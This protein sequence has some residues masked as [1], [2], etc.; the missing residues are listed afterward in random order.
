MNLFLVAVSTHLFE[1]DG[2]SSCTVT[3]QIFT[4]LKFFSF[5]VADAAVQAENLGKL[6]GNRSLWSL[7]LINPGDIYLLKV[8]LGNTGEQS[9]KSVQKL[10]LRNQKSD[11]NFVYDGVFIVHFE[12]IS[13]IVLI[14]PLSLNK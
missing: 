8:S 12:Q 9:V 6:P 1:L 10:K 13:H 14:F 4:D 5:K 2:I 3:F 11:N 7:I